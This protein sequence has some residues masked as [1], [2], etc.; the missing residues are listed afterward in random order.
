MDDKK[1]HRITAV[2]PFSTEK[3]LE[4]AKLL[5]EAGFCARVAKDRIDGKTVYFVE[6]WEEK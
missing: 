1:R 4:L 2:A 3:R 5:L 6:Y